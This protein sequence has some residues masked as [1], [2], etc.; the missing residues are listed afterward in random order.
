M[1]EAVKDNFDVSVSTY[2]EY[3]A[4][5]GQFS[6][7]ARRLAGKLVAHHDGSIERVLDAGA[8]TGASTG[9]L[10]DVASSVVALDLSREML[11]ANDCPDCVQADFDHLPFGRDEF[12]AIAFTAS[13]FLTPTPSVAVAEASRVL[14]DG[15]VVGAV[16]PNGWYLEG[17]SFFR[18]FDRD[19][20]SPSP[21]SEVRSALAEQFDLTTGEWTFESSADQLRQF[22]GIP[23]VGAR[24]YPELPPE[25]RVTRIRE[26][27]DDVDGQ[28]E[29]RWQWMVGSQLPS[30]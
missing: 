6:T 26:L 28:L 20:R 17:E 25:R 12:D 5:T 10:E 13:L 24:L 15:G 3:E 4:E 7:L 23:A 14:G 21:T 19:S 11:S 2:R 22:Y 27:L 18:R 9:P 1:K 16:A 30:L 29:Q 8:G